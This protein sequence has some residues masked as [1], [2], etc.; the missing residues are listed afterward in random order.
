MVARHGAARKGVLP[1]GL[2]RG[3]AQVAR[4]AGLVLA[5]SGCILDLE[6]PDLELAAPPSYREARGG[7][8]DTAL[9]PLDWWRTFRS[10]ELT[11]L[12]Q[13]AMTNNFTIAIAI[14]Q[15]LQADAQV[16]IVGAS[17][18]P[19]IGLNGSDEAE[20]A[21][22][23]L[24]GSGASGGAGGA[25]S[26]YSR[27][28]TT[29]LSASYIVDFWGK[30]K[31]A[32]NAAMETAIG[33]RY[34]REVV[35]LTTL[36]TVADTYFQ[37][38]AAQERLR[39]ARRDLADASRILFLIQQQ[40]GAGTASDLNVA[41]QESLVELVRA[42]IPPL[43]EIERQ[44]F[45]ALAV[46]IGRAP[47]QLR[48]RGTSLPG[49]T[50]PRITPGLPSDVINQR[51]DVRLAEQQLASANFSVQSAKA[52]F[53]PTLQL[54]GELG[55]ESVALRSLFGPGAWYYTAL[56]SLSQPLFDGGLLLGQLEQQ[57]GLQ[58]QYL[59]NY[60]QTL[61][62]A[63]S[64]VDQALVAIQETTE[65]ERIQ[66][67]VVKASRRAFVLSEQQMTA[68]T[69]NMVTLL[70]VE[71]TLFTAEDLLA[72]DQLSRLLAAV[73]LFQALGGGWPPKSGPPIQ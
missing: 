19:T 21:S 1:R 52:A 23:Q 7:T 5:L 3:F 31:A 34:N 64:N 33:S 30:N 69:V 46:L 13:Q 12:V 14:A 32:L 70:Q 2:L 48:V 45:D 60:R 56:A 65:Q 47:E 8:P 68:G 57:K 17:L 71:Q 63:F 15:I 20:K 66:E 36:A 53:F 72:Q 28:Y 18:L 42:S 37:I 73:G 35:T 38:I 10:P 67:N 59:Q 22:A 43:Q 16:R 54:T 27:L 50:I 61:L 6:K 62:S 26:L 41:Q 25:R 11:T 4:A 29:N 51:P 39:I 40:F 44:N 24:G 55:F 58:L 49:V 9:P